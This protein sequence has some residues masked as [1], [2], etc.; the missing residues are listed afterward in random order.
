MTGSTFARILG[1]ALVVGIAGGLLARIG[2]RGVAEATGGR[3]AFTLGGTAGIVLLFVVAAVGSGIAGL[4]RWPLVF[5]V[6]LSVASTALLALSGVS[7]GSGEILDAKGRGLSIAS[8]ILLTLLTLGI[9][10]AVLATPALAWTLGR[11]ERTRHF[12]AR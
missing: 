4:V 1:W 11:C 10:I 9:M 3:S 2:M 8:W 5:R 12:G 6:G 7:I